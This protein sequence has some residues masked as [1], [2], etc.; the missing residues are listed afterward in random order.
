M[1][2]MK[3][4]QK[5]VD[6][7]IAKFE[8]AKRTQLSR[9]KQKREDIL[10]ISEALGAWGDNNL[11]W[12]K[13]DLYDETYRIH[14]KDLPIEKWAEC[15]NS[16]ALKPQM[17]WGKDNKHDLSFRSD[18]T[19]YDDPRKS[20]VKFSFRSVVNSVV[21]MC[22]TVEFKEVM[23]RVN[24]EAESSKLGCSYGEHVNYMGGFRVK[25]S[26]L[27]LTESFNELLRDIN[28]GDTSQQI[29]GRGSDNYPNQFT[30]TCFNPEKSDGDDE[31]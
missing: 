31:S 8:E 17:Y 22:F 6:V 20:M 2:N 4:K 27:K 29:W 26:K 30:V 28:S 23:L 11:Y 9:L 15:Y 14:I 12:W 19:A 5:D 3:E 18:V 7:E 1:S 21:S 16:F 10:F 13:D 25:N 24:L